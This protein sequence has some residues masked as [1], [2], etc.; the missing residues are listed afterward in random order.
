[1]GRPAVR[2]TIHSPTVKALTS[3]PAHR[4]NAFGLAQTAPAH[5]TWKM[6]STRKNTPNGTYS[7]RCSPVTMKWMTPAPTE[8]RASVARSAVFVMS[9]LRDS[10]GAF[11]GTTAQGPGKMPPGS[12]IHTGRPDTFT[13]LKW[14]GSKCHVRVGYWGRRGP[15]G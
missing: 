8:V 4:T 1:M 2:E 5:S 6:A 13:D 12:A 14:F 10:E 11:T 3:T 15:T 7:S 9:S